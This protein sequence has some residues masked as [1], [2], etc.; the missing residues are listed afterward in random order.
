MLEDQDICHYL[1]DNKRENQKNAIFVPSLLNR[2]TYKC[3]QCEQPMC[4]DHVAKIC[5]ECSVGN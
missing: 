2:K 1:A 4:R 3:F 5:V